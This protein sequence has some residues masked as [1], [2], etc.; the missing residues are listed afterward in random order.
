MTSS[1]LLCPAQRDVGMQS[2]AYATIL[3]DDDDVH[4]LCVQVWV[5]MTMMMCLGMGG[6]DDSDVHILR[7][8]V[9]VMM[10]MMYLGMGD[11]EDDEHGYCVF[12]FG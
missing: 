11:D 9:W 12:G 1:C 5:M 4:I 7:V 8:W 2:P 3:T 10:M 6:D